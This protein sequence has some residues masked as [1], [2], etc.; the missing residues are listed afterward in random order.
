MQEPL[1]RWSSESTAAVTTLA[2]P[3][4]VMKRPRFS[5]WRTGSWPSFHSTTRTLPPSIPVSTPTKGMGSVSAKAARTCWRLS[6]GFG[7]RGEG[8]VM[9]ALFGRAPLMDGSQAE[10]AGQ[11]GGGRP[12][13]HP[14]KLEGNQ[15]QRQVLG[16]L[17]EA[18]VLRVEEGGGDAALVEGRQEA[19]LFR[20]PLVG[21][22]RALGDQPGD[23]SARHG[24]GG[25]DEHGEVIAVGEAPHELAQVVPGQGL[26]RGR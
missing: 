1:R 9:V 14:G 20:R 24:A 21:I 4:L 12:G 23:R 7:R 11:A 8:Q 2:K 18:A 15:R 13:I 25:L 22:A 6:P 17:D 19:G 26:E 10:V 3:M 5:T 16:P